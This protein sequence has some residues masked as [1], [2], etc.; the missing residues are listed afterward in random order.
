[1]RFEFGKIKYFEGRRGTVQA[2]RKFERTTL[3]GSLILDLSFDLGGSQNK[4]II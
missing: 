1:L 3:I 4:K 2:L